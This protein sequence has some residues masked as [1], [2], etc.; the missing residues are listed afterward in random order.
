MFGSPEANA[1]GCIPIPTEH[2]LYKALLAYEEVKATDDM[3]RQR[4]HFNTVLDIAASN[5]WTI[6]I[7]TS[8][9]YVVN[10]QNGFSNVTSKAAQ[11]FSFLSPGNT[12]QETYYFANARH[13]PEQAAAIKRDI[14]TI[15]PEP[16]TFAAETNA[17]GAAGPTWLGRTI[18]WT[19][20]GVAAA[21][22]LMAAI[23]HPYIGRRLLIMI[24]T[25][26]FI[27]IV[28]FSIIQLPPGDFLTSKIV[29]LQMKG[30]AVDEQ[31]LANIKAMHH[32]DDPM[33]IRY[34]RWMGLAW[35]FSFDAKDEGLLQGNLGRSMASNREVSQIVGDRITLTILLS[36]GSILFT[37]AIALP[38]GI[39]SAVRQYSIADYILTFIG[40][41]GMCIPSFLLAVVLM[42]WSQEYLGMQISGLFSPK[43]AMQPYWDWAKFVDLMK[44]L[45][46]PVVILGIGGTGGMIRVMRGNLLDELKKPYVVTARAKGVRPA[47]LLFK[48]PV[49]IALNPFISGIG[50]L[51]PALISG[52]T[53]I[54]VVLSLPT[55]GPMMLEALM[56]EDTLLAG[57][58]LMVLSVLGVL[59]V[60]ISDLLLLWLDPRI[61]FEE[62]SR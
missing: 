55:V 44:H 62:G 1:P 28:V 56:N 41:I 2:P 58:M 51:F 33:V 45:W 59:G 13:T 23:R 38:V 36:L 37:W 17:D 54:S 61:R 8:P 15:T 60:L 21:F 39:Y 40:F 47:K 50:G 7:C 57:S 30:D 29:E 20:I 12:G 24:P 22:V 52:G 16:R 6:G 26:F 19:I 25:L 42:Y 27:S 35:F 46:I 10:I 49:R 11:T 53:L 14:T 4:E 32:L 5:T 43:Y 18:Q 9:K 3:A 31:E 48:Y 34:C